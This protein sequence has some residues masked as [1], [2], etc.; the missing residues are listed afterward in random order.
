MR[1]VFDVLVVILGNIFEELFVLVLVLKRLV[2]RLV[3]GQFAAAVQ[4]VAILKLVL[5]YPVVSLLLEAVVRLLLLEGQ[6]G[7]RVGM[8]KGRTALSYIFG[9]VL[10]NI[11]Y[12]GRADFHVLDQVLIAG[13]R[14]AKVLWLWGQVLI[15]LG[16]QMP[17]KLR[18]NRKVDLRQK[19]LDL[20]RVLSR[21]LTLIH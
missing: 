11:R 10:A 18:S 9:V 20:F 6:V 12:G 4:A 16:R 5:Q 15:R 3:A 8:V 2:E 14:L 21:W 13:Q 17:V 19:P 1:L 7:L